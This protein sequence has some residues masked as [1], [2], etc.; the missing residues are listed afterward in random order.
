[1]KGKFH[2]GTS[3]W[4]Y[5][6]WKGCFY[7]EYLKEREWLKYYVEYFS[8]TEINTS[9]YHLPKE[10]TV[11]NWANS[12]PASFKFCPKISRYITHMKKLKDVEEPL[13]RFFNSFDH[14]AGKTGPVLVQLPKM[15]GFKEEKTEQFYSLTA[16]R[17]RDYTFAMEIRHESWLSNQSIALMRKYG[18]AFVI[19]QSGG[20][21]PYK[22]LVTAKDIYIRFHGPGSLYSSRYSTQMLKRFAR[23][24]KEW[25]SDGHVIWAY[26]NNDVNC[27]APHDA[28][29]LIAMLEEQA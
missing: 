26:F 23:M 3:G 14:M 1:M 10:Q 16:D 19:S 27:Y 29:R 8:T 17:Y 15:V 13:E 28:L 5:K 22:E 24:C 6:H 21:F 7:P 20:F 18:I 25:M 9:F 12:V 4:N 11:I 2:I